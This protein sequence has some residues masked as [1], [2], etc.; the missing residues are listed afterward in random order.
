MGFASKIAASQSGGGV[1]SGAPPA[2]YTGGPPPAQGGA[3]QY[4]PGQQ[5]Y[6]AYQPSQPQGGQQ[7]PVGP[8]L[9]S[10]Y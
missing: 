8:Y 3:P 1:Y 10:S 5:Q 2:G 9:F 4:Q 6:Q 7:T